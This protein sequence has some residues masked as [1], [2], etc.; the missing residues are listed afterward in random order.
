MEGLEGIYLKLGFLWGS[1]KGSF[2]G[3]KGFKARESRNK[4]KTS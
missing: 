3:F 2:R 1:F 4:L